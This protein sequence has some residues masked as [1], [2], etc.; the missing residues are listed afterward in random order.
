MEIQVTMKLALTMAW[1]KRI[2]HY[3]VFYEWLD[4]CMIMTMG[5]RDLYHVTF[6]STGC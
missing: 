4:I 5:G 3:D 6:Q 1:R 2:D